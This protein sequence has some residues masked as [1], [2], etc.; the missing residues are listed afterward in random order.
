MAVTAAVSAP[1][2]PLTVHLY[3]PQGTTGGFVLATEGPT[4]PEVPGS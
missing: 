3:L 4:Q 1:P 2:G